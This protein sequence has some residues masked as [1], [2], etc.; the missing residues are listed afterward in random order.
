[1]YRRNTENMKHEGRTVNG[2]PLTAYPQLLHTPLHQIKH[3]LA[4]GSRLSTLRFEAFIVAVAECDA[5]S[6]ANFHEIRMQTLAIAITRVVTV[7]IR[8][9]IA[10]GELGK[11]LFDERQVPLSRGGP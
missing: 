5:V 9:A 3:K 2:Y 11:F 8:R 10:M 1:M 6:R 7:S 4:L